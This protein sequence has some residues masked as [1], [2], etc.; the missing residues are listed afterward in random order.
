MTYVVLAS[1]RMLRRSDRF[2]RKDKL[3]IAV[4][5]GAVLAA[6]VACGPVNEAQ[7]N[8]SAF[9]PAPRLDCAHKT[10]FVGLRSIK[11]C[12]WSQKFASRFIDSSNSLVVNVSAGALDNEAGG[13]SVLRLALLPQK[14]LSLTAPILPTSI[15][16]RLERRGEQASK[17]FVGIASM[18]N[19]N[20]PNDRDS[21]DAQTASGEMYDV[22]VWTAAI[23]IDLR[24]QFG[25]VRYGRNYKPSY[26]LLEAAG[27]RVIVKINDVGPLVFGRIIDLN[28]RTMQ[29]FDSSLQRGLVPGMRV[30]PL[31]GT[32]WATGPLG[33]DDET[34]KLAGDVGM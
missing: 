34:I 12:S 24:D 26:V 5:Y 19:P 2:A 6:F 33:N 3:A 28:K 21:G 10:H 8:S 11:Q 29:Y 4:A 20:D 16:T 1:R 14:P 23:R 22:S 27:K 18:Y 30:I 9:V 15:E 7:A 31:P 13:V 17:M 25:G 32:H